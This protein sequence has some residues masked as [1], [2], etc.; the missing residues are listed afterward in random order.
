MS[1]LTKRMHCRENHV[2]FPL[3]QELRR[4]QRL[5]LS[6]AGRPPH[7]VPLSSTVCADSLRFRVRDRQMEMI[8]GEAFCLAAQPGR[9]W[10]RSEYRQRPAGPRAAQPVALMRELAD[11]GPLRHSGHGDVPCCCRPR[12]KEKATR[13]QPAPQRGSH[14]VGRLS[15]SWRLTDRENWGSLTCVLLGVFL[16]CIPV[17][18]GYAPGT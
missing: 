3:P 18:L 16:D 8:K 14:L 13:V 9:T 7:P 5:S 15:G 4:E 6:T 1:L 10:R 17:N 12:P 2:V 11:P